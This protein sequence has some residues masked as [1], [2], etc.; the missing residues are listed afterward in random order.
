MITVYVKEHL[1][2]DAIWT[3]LESSLSDSMYREEKMNQRT[4]IYHTTVRVA[5]GVSP[6]SR[7]GPFSQ[8][9][10][11]SYKN[12]LFRKMKFLTREVP[13][14][15]FCIIYNSYSLILSS[16]W[17]LV[18]ISWNNTNSSHTV[19]GCIFTMASA[20]YGGILSLKG[21]GRHPRSPHSPLTPSNWT[22]KKVCN[23]R[24]FL[25]AVSLGQDSWNLII[26]KYI[27]CTSLA[28]VIW[29]TVKDLTGIELL[30]LKMR[31]GN[32]K[33]IEL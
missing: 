10:T 12:S 30:G 25:F 20:Q 29:S 21:M 16:V 1:Q 14:D 18:Y 19:L 27:A 7:H 4:L 9:N 33:I 6:G 5:A 32:G 17:K 22:H 8:P 24:V 2:Q 3:R 13:Y 23:T 31:Q 26:E 15:V 11:L 28:G